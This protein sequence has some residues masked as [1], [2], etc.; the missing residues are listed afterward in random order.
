MPDTCQ[1][2]IV[3]NY[4]AGVRTGRILISIGANREI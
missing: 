2:M 4:D 1:M 3:S